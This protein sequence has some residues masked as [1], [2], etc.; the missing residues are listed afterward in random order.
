V[1]YAKI[2]YELIL[3][4][5][6][7]ESIIIIYSFYILGWTCYP[8]YSNTIAHWTL[9]NNQSINRVKG[10]TD[11]NWINEMDQAMWITWWLIEDT[12]DF[13]AIKG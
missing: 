1:I 8:E 3:Q 6:F 13:T 9:S 2:S 10:I 5:K 7:T 11:F 12:N 4:K